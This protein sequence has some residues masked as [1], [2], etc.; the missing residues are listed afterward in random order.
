[1]SFGGWR[2][3]W[4]AAGDDRRTHGQGEGGGRELLGGSPGQ[5]RSRGKSGSGRK[6][7]C[8]PTMA[9]SG[10][11]SPAALISWGAGVI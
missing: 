8:P 3:P 11:Q 7:S 9:P 1:M 5:G 10:A 6:A 2:E 4:R